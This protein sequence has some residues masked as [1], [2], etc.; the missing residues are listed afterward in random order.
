DRLDGGS[1][2]TGASYYLFQG[3]TE[4][5]SDVVTDDPLDGGHTV[6][7][8]LLPG[9]YRLEVRRYNTPGIPSTG[10]AAFPSIVTVVIGTS[11]EGT[12]SRVVVRSALPPLAPTVSG[13]I[14]AQNQLGHRVVLPPVPPDAAWD[15]D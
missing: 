14:V 15:Y 13:D 5:P 6:I 8:G 3:S 11:I 9:T 7:D 2:V 4:V 10:Q 1:P 12:T